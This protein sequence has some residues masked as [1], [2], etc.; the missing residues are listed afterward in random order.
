M[1]TQQVNRGGVVRRDKRTG[2]LVE[3]PGT[4]RDLLVK[5]SEQLTPPGATTQ[6]PAILSRAEIARRRD[7]NR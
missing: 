3:E 1:R 7:A 6:S 2:E 5:P 4:Y